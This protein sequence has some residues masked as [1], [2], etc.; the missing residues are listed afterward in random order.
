LLY[1]WHY[2]YRVI[3]YYLKKLE[4]PILASKTQEEV[5]V[6]LKA[7]KPSKSPGGEGGFNWPEMLEEALYFSI[8][9]SLID[10]LNE[11]KTHRHYFKPCPK[12]GG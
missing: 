9:D 2:F 11:K 8:D 5:L 10:K 1:G 4:G 12:R 7:S 6:A 3:I